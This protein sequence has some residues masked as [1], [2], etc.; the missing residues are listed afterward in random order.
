VVE[1]RLSAFHRQALRRLGSRRAEDA[2]QDAL[3]SAYTHLINSGAGADGHL[4][5]TIVINSALM[6]LAPGARDN[7]T[8]PSKKQDGDRAHLSLS[9]T[10]PITAKSKRSAPG[11]V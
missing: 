1:R 8:F 6:K 3:L 5:D 2:V 7:C 9:E 10:L 4:G 11:R